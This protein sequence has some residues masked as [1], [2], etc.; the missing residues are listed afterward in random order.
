MVTTVATKEMSD[1]HKE[2]LAVGRAQGRTVRAYLE[3]LETTKPKRGRKRTAESIT[4]RLAKI[5]TELDDADPLKKLQLTQ[6]QL[7]LTTELETLESATDVTELEGEFEK[8]AKDYAER[9]GISYKA[10]R[11]LGVPAAVLKNAGIG[12]SD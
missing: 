1:E 4:A 10:Y 2:A 3:A 6:E 5:E 12:R 7:D 11:Q 9:K 8:V